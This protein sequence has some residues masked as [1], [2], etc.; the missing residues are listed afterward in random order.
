MEKGLPAPGETSSNRSRTTVLGSC[1]VL[2]RLSDDVRPPRLVCDCTLIRRLVGDAVAAYSGRS[3][4]LSG[5]TTTPKVPGRCVS[6]FRS[7]S[8]SV[9]RT[10]NAGMSSYRGTGLLLGDDRACAARGGQTGGRRRTGRHLR[11]H[12]ALPCVVTLV[13]LD[14]VLGVASLN[15]IE[16]SV[17]VCPACA[18]DSHSRSIDGPSRSLDSVVYTAV[19]SSATVDPTVSQYR[20]TYTTSGMDL[21]ALDLPSAT[22]PAAGARAVRQP[23]GPSGR[24]AGSLAAGGGLGVAGGQRREVAATAMRG[25]GGRLV[26]RSHGGRWSGPTV[27]RATRSAGRVC[28]GG[29][30]AWQ[31]FARGKANED[32]VTCSACMGCRGAF[33]V[34]HGKGGQREEWSCAV[35]VVVVV[36]GRRTRRGISV[37]WRIPQQAERTWHTVTAMPDETLGRGGGVDGTT[38]TEGELAWACRRS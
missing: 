28:G 16:V 19:P 3:E 15:W 22:G 17:E 29:G 31:R 38:P 11:S 34:Q 4:K 8:S 27:C 2:V 24:R 33:R 20:N 9:C 30:W 37:G 35:L 6:A 25:G 26:R 36:C 13:Y 23:R 1:R 7:R 14:W 5:V 10:E 12:T 21:V 18:I 32:A